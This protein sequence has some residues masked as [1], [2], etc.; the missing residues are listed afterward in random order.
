VQQLFEETIT[1]GTIQSVN[2]TIEQA[3]TELSDI[4][5]SLKISAEEIK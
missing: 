4:Q 2:E 5:S 1:G 3:A